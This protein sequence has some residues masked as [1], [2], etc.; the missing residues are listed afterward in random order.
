MDRI[1]LSLTSFFRYWKPLVIVSLL[2]AISSCK[3][4]PEYDA[5]LKRQKEIDEAMEFSKELANAEPFDFQAMQEKII[6]EPGN[7]CRL[8]AEFLYVD[9]GQAPDFFYDGSGS[10]YSDLWTNIYYREFFPEM[11]KY[12]LLKGGRNPSWNHSLEMPRIVYELYDYNHRDSTGINK[13]IKVINVYGDQ[14]VTHI[15]D[16]PGTKPRFVNEDKN[17]VFEMQDKYFVVDEFMKV[18]NVTPEEYQ[19]LIKKPESACKWKVVMNYRDLPGIWIQSLD[20]RT[21]CHLWPSEKIETVEVIPNNCWIYFWGSETA[22]IIKPKPIQLKNFVISIG[23]AQGIQLG[24]LLDV[25]DKQISP[26]TGEVIGYHKDRWKGTLRVIEVQDAKCTAEFQTR[27][28]REGVFISDS[29][30]LTTN[31]TIM[32]T[33]QELTD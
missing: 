2:V 5:K 7:V 28:G 25:Y 4:D 11:R 14:E 24:D 29:A 21:Y 20:E 31:P 22:G 18:Q 19:N 1:R 23:S 16:L 17:I 9:M 32:G 27:L 3:K 10:T 15:T 33:I 26:L 6:K 30:V 8:S 12:K 13:G